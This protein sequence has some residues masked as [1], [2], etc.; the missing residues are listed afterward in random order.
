MTAATAQE[1]GD[2]IEEHKT[3]CCRACSLFEEACTD[4]AGYM[5]QR[6]CGATELWMCCCQLR[7]CGT[8]RAGGSWSGQPPDSE[9]GPKQDGPCSRRLVRHHEGPHCYQGVSWLHLHAC[10]HHICTR[11]LCLLHARRTANGIPA[12]TTTGSLKEFQQ[13]HPGPEANCRKVHRGTRKN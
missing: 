2:C 11:K 7:M 4:L 1:V 10:K 3:L 8:T 12:D 13:L 9:R 5:R 6:D